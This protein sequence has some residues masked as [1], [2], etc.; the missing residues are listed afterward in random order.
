MFII[1]SNTGEET[2]GE[3][4]AS[5]ETELASDVR[6]TQVKVAEKM[7]SGMPLGVEEISFYLRW[8]LPRDVHCTPDQVYFPA[9]FVSK[10]SENGTFT[11]GNVQESTAGEWID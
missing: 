6:K 11:Y 2:A 1:C 8:V 9:D 3:E 10:L 4:D 7:L 5:E